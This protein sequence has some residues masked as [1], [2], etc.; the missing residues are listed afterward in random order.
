MKRS[1]YQE[2]Q[3]QAAGLAQKVLPFI[4]PAQI[5]IAGFGLED[6]SQLLA[7]VN[8][9]NETFCGKLLISLPGWT[10]PSHHHLSLEGKKDEGF[11]VVFGQ[12]VVIEPYDAG[13]HV[14]NAGEPIYMPAGTKHALTAGPE[15][16]VYFEFSERDE[17]IDVFSNP[18]VT[19]DPEIEEDV[20]GYSA[21][22]GG[23]QILGDG[24]IRLKPHVKLGI[25]DAQ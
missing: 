19:R 7:L 5:E 25:V 23:F 24:G 12:L 9:F 11:F 20:P 21:P 13:R 4:Q 2:L 1:R 3:K 22:E 6:E 15:G 8:L 17:R 16:A 18:T 10:C 14:A